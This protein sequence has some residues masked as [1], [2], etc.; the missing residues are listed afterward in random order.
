MFL[1]NFIDVNFIQA[2]TTFYT[3]NK[4]PG[5]SVVYMS[6]NGEKNCNYNNETNS[7]NNSTN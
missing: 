4:L 5:N 7:T 6:F 1:G 2:A 3:N